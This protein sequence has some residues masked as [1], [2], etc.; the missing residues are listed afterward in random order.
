MDTAEIA[1]GAEMPKTF[2]PREVGETLIPEEHK[3]IVRERIK[4][5]E[6]SLDSYLSW[7]DIEREM[8]ARK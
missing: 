3:H 2:T 7:D 8:A 6:N 4:K 5:F 1:K